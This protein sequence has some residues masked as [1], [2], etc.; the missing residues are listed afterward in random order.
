MEVKLNVFVSHKKMWFYIYSYLILTLFSWSFASIKVRVSKKKT[1]EFLVETN[2]KR[3][4]GMFKRSSQERSALANEC[5]F[6][7]IGLFWENRKEKK[8]RNASKIKSDF[9]N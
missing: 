2:E 8:T 9:P 1:E 3:L 5:S 4:S 7:S 6:F